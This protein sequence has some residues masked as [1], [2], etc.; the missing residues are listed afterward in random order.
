MVGGVEAPLGLGGMVLVVVVAVE[1]GGM[2]P[3]RNHCRH[4]MG[5]WWGRRG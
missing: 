5:R 4:V 1:E 2:E 3:M